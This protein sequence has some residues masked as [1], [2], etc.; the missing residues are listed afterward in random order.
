MQVSI[1]NIKGE[2]VIK[3]PEKRYNRGLNNVV[4]NGFDYNN[5]AVSSGIYFY[6][7]ASDSWQESHKMLLLK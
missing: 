2:L 3:Y 6:Q 4:W 7:V 5:K 1:Y